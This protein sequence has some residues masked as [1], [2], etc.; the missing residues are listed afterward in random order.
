MDFD[1][2]VMAINVRE[3]TSVG[4]MIASIKIIEIDP[5][6]LLQFRK[7]CLMSTEEDIGSLF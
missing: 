7:F 2:V 5:Y 6:L 4:N 3:L 1:K